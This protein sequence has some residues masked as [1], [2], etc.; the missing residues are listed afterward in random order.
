MNR[1]RINSSSEM[2]ERR[3]EVG[4]RPSLPGKREA[5]ES[6]DKTAIRDPHLPHRWPGWGTA[7]ERVEKPDVSST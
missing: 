4:V 6:S 1:T 7:V 3:S 2:Q 5:R